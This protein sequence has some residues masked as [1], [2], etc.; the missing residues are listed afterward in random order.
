MGWFIL[1]IFLKII[2]GIICA[3]L[4]PIVFII[5]GVKSI[6]DGIYHGDWH[7]DCWTEEVPDLF[8]KL[9]DHFKTPIFD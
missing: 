7:E 6:I 8:R 2:T 4:L 1:E 3:A 9:Y 5:C